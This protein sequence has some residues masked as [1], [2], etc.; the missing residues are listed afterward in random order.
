MKLPSLIR[1]LAYYPL[2][3]FHM[4]GNEVA[5]HSP[6]VIKRDFRALGRLI[7][8]SEEVMRRGAM[9]DFDLTNK[10]GLVGNV[11]LKCSLGCSDHEMVELKILRVARRVR[12]KL[13]PLDSGEQ[14]L[15]S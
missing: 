7:K 8:E 9:L 13:T 5:T 12:N 11:K 4:S 6:R 2:S 10:E 14:T 15:A 3:L 1:P